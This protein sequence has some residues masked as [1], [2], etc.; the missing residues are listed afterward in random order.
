MR[1]F[2]L[3]S[4]F[5]VG[6]G[7][8]GCAS[9]QSASSGNEEGDAVN[10]GYGKQ[11][12]A[13]VTSATS[14]VTPDQQSQSGTNSFSDLLQGQTAGVQ[15]EQAPNGTRILIRGLTSVHGDNAPLYVVD[16]MTVAPNPDGTVPVHPREVKSI[17]VLKD[18]GATSIYGSQG[19][20]GVIVIETKDR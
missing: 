11:K 19:A 10:V 18:A 20:N 1:A 6:I 4:I 13:N 12:Q 5:V 16:G 17:T 3:L 15:V 14:T 2:R 7:L 8:I 9:S